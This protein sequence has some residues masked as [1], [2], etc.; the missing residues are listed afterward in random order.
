[1]P[2]LTAQQFL[3]QITRTGEVIAAVHRSISC[4]P[5]APYKTQLEPMLQQYVLPCFDAPAGH[6]RA[7]ACWVTQQYADIKFADGRGR[8]PTFMQLF[9]KTL[10]RLNDPELPVSP[11]SHPVH[12]THDP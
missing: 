9:Q 10:D 11:A 5:Q 12:S 1:M 7:K 8:G 3:V 2:M 6:V 4:N